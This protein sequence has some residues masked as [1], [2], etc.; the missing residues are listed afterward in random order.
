MENES[1]AT[2]LLKEI[3]SSARRWFIIALIE[4]IVILGLGSGFIWYMT[5]PSEEYSV[6]Q[7]A[8]HNSYNIV[9]TGEG[10]ISNGTTKDNLQTPSNP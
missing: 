1:L 6:E 10:D 5:L 2:E 8:D 7:D 3:K 9:N 4:L